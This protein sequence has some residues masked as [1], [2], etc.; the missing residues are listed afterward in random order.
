[1]EINYNF[2]PQY[3]SDEI[4]FKSDAVSYAGKL[5]EIIGCETVI[6]TLDEDN[7]PVILSTNGKLVDPL[8]VTLETY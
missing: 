5:L 1:M 6:V 7:K 3:K 4:R 8:N 2:V